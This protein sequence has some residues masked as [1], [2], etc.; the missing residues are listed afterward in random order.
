MSLQYLCH[1]YVYIH[2]HTYIYG[3]GQSNAGIGGMFTFKPFDDHFVYC[4]KHE[5]DVKDCN[6]VTLSGSVGPKWMLFLIDGIQ[7]I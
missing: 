2:T 1:S 4:S 5:A 6:H 3:G 7:S